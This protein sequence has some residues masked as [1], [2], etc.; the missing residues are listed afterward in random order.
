MA[1]FLGVTRERIYSP[2]KVEADRA[3]LEEVAARLRRGHDVTVANADES[4]PEPEP[5]T[6]VFTMAQGPRALAAMRRWQ[7]RGIRIVNTPRAI[8]SCHRGPMIA[9]F[10]RHGVKHPRTAVV[11]TAAPAWPHWLQEPFWLK[12]GDVH[13]TEPGDVT[14]VESRAQARE[15]CAGFAARGIATALVQAHVEGTVVKFYGVS[16][17][18]FACFEE[19]DAGGELPPPAPSFEP[20]GT[21]SASFH[22]GRN[23]GRMSLPAAHAAAALGLEIYGGDCVRAADG[24]IYFIDM[25]DWPSYGR[26]RSSAADAIAACL[27]EHASEERQ[28]RM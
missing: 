18:F 5:G 26:C 19:G 23:P 6:T 12:R 22:E 28:G 24:G 1:R 9:A 17:K 13:A 20:P 14:R 7:G 2:G 4:L 25:N 16:G 10:E 21:V 11:E 15:I 3:I 8:E 27:E